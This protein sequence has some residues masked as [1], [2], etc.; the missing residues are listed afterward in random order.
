MPCKC[1]KDGKSSMK[2]I[3][4]S[5]SV[6]RT[7]RENSGY[8]QED[9]AKKLKI[10]LDRVI[11]IENGEDS[12]TLS[13]IKRLSSLYKY[14]LAA[15]FSDYV[16]P[17]PKLLNFTRNRTHKPKTFYFDK[18]ANYCYRCIICNKEVKATNPFTLLELIKEHFVK[19]EEKDTSVP[20]L[21]I[22]IK[23]IEEDVEEML[24]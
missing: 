2:K 24:L 14:P 7:L 10:P 19:H 22:E 5:S 17:L 16:E 3:N 1:E 9:I 6:L 21:S 13:Q 8:T 23:R 12:F 20:D 11:A 4:T 18:Y 15:F